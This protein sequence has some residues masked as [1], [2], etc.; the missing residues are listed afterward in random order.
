MSPKRHTVAIA[1]GLVLAL[2]L[3]SHPSTQEFGSITFPTSGAAGAQD[4]FLTGVKA[5]HNFQFDEAAVAFQ[6]AQKADPS[7]A[8]AYWGEA[9]SHNHPL[10]AQQDAAK[11]KAA[12]HS[13]PPRGPHI[14]G[15]RRE[16]VLRAS[17]YISPGDKPRDTY[18]QAAAKCTQWPDD[19]GRSSMHCRCRPCGRNCFRRGAGRVIAR[20]LRREPEHPGAA[21]FIIHAFDDPD[22]APLGLPAARSYAGI[23]PS[24]AHALHMPSHIFVQLGM[25]EDVRKSNIVAYKAAA[26]LNTRMKLAEGR[27][28]FHTLA[29]EVLT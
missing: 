29:G 16:G 26:D 23:A 7:F 13:S 27:E 4:A 14:G 15:W 20:R 1:A 12:L 5:L 3:S 6:Q 21:H 10:W 17:R 11:A 24:A 18:S 9:M 19:H 22:H 8:M 2:A 25:W 28:D